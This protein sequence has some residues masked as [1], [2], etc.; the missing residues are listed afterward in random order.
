MPRVRWDKL[1]RLAMGGILVTLVYLYVSAGV[2]L[3]GAVG[4]SSADK[5]KVVSLERQNKQLKREHAALAGPSIRDAESR[6]MGMAR[7]GENVYVV[8]HL[9]RD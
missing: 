7:P 2:S 6:R 1:G 4:N 9:P 8:R 3:L 5:A